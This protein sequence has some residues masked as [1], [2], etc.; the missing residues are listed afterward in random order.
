[1]PVLDEIWCTPKVTYFYFCN[2]CLDLRKCQGYKKRM[3]SP[4][5]VAV[6]HGSCNA[7]VGERR[8]K[9]AEMVLRI[10]IV[11]LGGVAAVL[12]GTNTEVKLI[13][14]ISK[15]ASFTDMKALV[16]LVVA[17]AVVAA[18]SLVHLVRCVAGMARGSILFSKPLAWLIFSG[19][20]VMAYLSVAA[21]AAAAQSS[22]LG[23]F[24]QTEL[25]W[26]QICDLYAKFCNQVGE[27]IAASLVV[28]ICS[29]IL[30]SIS[31]YSLFRLY[32]GRKGKNDTRW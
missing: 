16:F 2:V 27:G 19:D 5:N 30:S 9:M 14:S 4:G 13:F 3:S 15:K 6:Y 29:V 12:I 24:G 22:V 8:I 11:A 31:A 10:L 20:Q 28:S 26:M 21:V 7:R 32:G 23:K 25:Q 1:M 18:Y 17:N